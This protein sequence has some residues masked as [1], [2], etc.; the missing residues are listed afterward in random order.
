MH[1]I[2]LLPFTNLIKIGIKF[3]LQD[4]SVTLVKKLAGGYH[5]CQHDCN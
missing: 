2:F 1:F 4:I 3:C 5:F